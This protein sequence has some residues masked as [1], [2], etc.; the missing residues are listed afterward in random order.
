MVLVARVYM[1]L[2]TLH[3]LSIRRLPFTY[4]KHSIHHPQPCQYNLN[5]IPLYCMLYQYVTPCRVIFS[6]HPSLALHRL[7]SNTPFLISCVISVIPA[8]TLRGLSIIHAFISRWTPVSHLACLRSLDVNITLFFVYENSSHWRINLGLVI[9]F[10]HTFLP[11]LPSLSL[12]QHLWNANAR[13]L[14]KEERGERKERREKRGGKP[15]QGVMR[16]KEGS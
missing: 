6:F 13:L 15:R 1:N 10:L 4:F 5:F 2:S 16:D 9:S 14:H 3:F 11:V 7:I 8:I 12:T